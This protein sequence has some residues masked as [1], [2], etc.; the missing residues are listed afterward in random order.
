MVTA[1]Q[2]EIQVRI[3]VAVMVY[4]MLWVEEEEKETTN[5]AG[6]VDWQHDQYDG[7]RTLPFTCD[8]PCHAS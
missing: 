8:V 7:N 6:N 3:L 2:T 1:A 4:V 5:C